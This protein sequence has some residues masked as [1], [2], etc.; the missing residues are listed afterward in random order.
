M[1]KWTSVRMTLV[2][3]I[4]MNLK[5]KKQ[6]DVT[7]VF[8]HADL[9]QEKKVLSNIGWRSTHVSNFAGVIFLVLANGTPDQ[10]ISLE[11]DKRS[12]RILIPTHTMSILVSIQT[13]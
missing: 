11:S 8:L 3:D 5:S 9:S 7:A 6:G 12:R 1:V 2:L 13:D 4:L 10:L